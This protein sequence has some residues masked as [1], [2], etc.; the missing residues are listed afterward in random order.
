MLETF[1]VD[2]RGE[3]RGAV[4]W[5]HGLGASNHDFEDI[6]PMLDRPDL[7]FIFPAA[8]VKPVTING[9]YP[10]PSWYD[11]LSFD[12]PPLR[13]RESD[14]RASAQA[15]EALIDLQIQRGIA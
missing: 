3:P 14:V 1:E 10:M 5:M 13:E 15:I 9:G 11:I 2:A 4:V 8:P 7:R 6:L 12:N